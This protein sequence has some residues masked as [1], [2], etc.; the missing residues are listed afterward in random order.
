MGIMEENAM[1]LVYILLRQPRLVSFDNAI[2]AQ[3]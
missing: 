2:S 3:N 1:Q